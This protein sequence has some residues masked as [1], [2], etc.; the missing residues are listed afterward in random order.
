MLDAAVDGQSLI[1][2]F[3]GAPEADAAFAVELWRLIDP[4]SGTRPRRISTQVAAPEK[5]TNADAE[6]HLRYVIPEIDLT[7][8]NRIGLVITRVDA[9][10]ADDPVGEYTIRLTPT[11]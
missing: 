2:E 11:L 5:L 7:K 6:G 1:L 3:C 4:G 9:C 10:E 8:S